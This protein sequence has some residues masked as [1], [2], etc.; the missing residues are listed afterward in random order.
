MTFVSIFLFSTMFFC[1]G[2]TYDSAN[3]KQG[4]EFGNNE[5]PP[6]KINNSILFLDF[7]EQ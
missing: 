1:I 6:K 2:G 4:A 5:P 3:C 7:T